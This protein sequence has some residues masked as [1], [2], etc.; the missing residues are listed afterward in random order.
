MLIGCE[1]QYADVESCMKAHRGNVADCNEQWARIPRLSEPFAKRCVG[2]SLYP[3]R[4][5]PLALVAFW[6]GG[7]SL[8]ASVSVVTRTP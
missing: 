8:V 4:S 1:P 7:K 5:L 3:H 6:A 2:C